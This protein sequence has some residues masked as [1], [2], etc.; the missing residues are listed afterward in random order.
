MSD[1]QERRRDR[2][3]ALANS[4]SRGLRYEAADRHVQAGIDVARIT[5]QDI[6]PD[7]YT[8]FLSGWDE[9]M[10]LT[11]GELAEENHNLHGIIFDLCTRLCIE[12][13]KAC[14]G[15]G[16]IGIEAC[17]HCEQGWIDKPESK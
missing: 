12:R 6:Q 15:D 10:S 1:P 7:P 3:N 17:P 5:G 14:N 9:A 8:D 4:L 16:M 13:C 11:Q 2:I